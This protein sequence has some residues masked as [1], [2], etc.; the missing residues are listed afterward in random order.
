MK[1]KFV[2]P[3]IESYHYAVVTQLGGSGDTPSGPIL[4]PHDAGNGGAP[5]S[6]TA[7]NGHKSCA[8]PSLPSSAM[9]SPCPH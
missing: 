4:G 9:A 6:M 2:S 8:L 3:T 1:K 7:S 5:C